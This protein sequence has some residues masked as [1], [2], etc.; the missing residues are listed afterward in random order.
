MR[1]FLEHAIKHK[2]VLTKEFLLAYS[3]YYNKNRKWLTC[4]VSNVSVQDVINN[5]CDALE[6]SGHDLES[7]PT[8]VVFDQIENMI[9]IEQESPIEYIQLLAALETSEEAL[10]TARSFDIKNQTVEKNILKAIN[11][12]KLQIERVKNDKS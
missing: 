9:K 8:S 2:E 4:S 3:E 11:N 10:R 7:T 1:A 5:A 12:I 6:K